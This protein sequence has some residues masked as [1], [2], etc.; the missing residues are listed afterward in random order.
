MSKRKK[1]NFGTRGK[2]PKGKHIPITKQP[3]SFT[4]TH[5][6]WS[7]LYA[8]K[9]QWSIT[10]E[11]S[12]KIFMTEVISKL[13]D[14]E[15]QTWDEINIKNK[16]R[17]HRDHDL[18]YNKCAID[19]AEEIGLELGSVQSLRLSGTHRLYGFLDEGWIFRIVWFDIDHGENKTCVCPSYK[20]C[21]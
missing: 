4:G 14:L 21:T 11:K 8:D 1:G 18:K 19:R 10:S 5:P 2:T 12:Q 13:R 17:N 15:T 9:D 7:F 6:V 3:K 20:K 16:S